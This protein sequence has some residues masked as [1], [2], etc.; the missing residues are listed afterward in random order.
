MGVSSDVPHQVPSGDEC[1][2][3]LKGVESN[4]QE[5]KDVWMMQVFPRHG[6]PVEDL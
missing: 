5:G 4:T 3:E 1:R 2:N 6:L